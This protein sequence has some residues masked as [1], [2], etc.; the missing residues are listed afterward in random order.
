MRRAAGEL[1]GHGPAL[2]LQFSGKMSGLMEILNGA[3]A[4]LLQAREPCGAGE[5]VRSAVP[6]Y[7]ST[8]CAWWAITHWVALATA[9]TAVLCSS[10][11]SGLIN[12][13]WAPGRHIHHNASMRPVSA[14]SK[15]SV[16]H[17][18]PVQRV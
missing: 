5:Q 13:R 1:A 8:R 16:A 18:A 4:Y 10:M 3:Y 6:S 17:A 7:R 2:G 9:P 14:D 11:Q 15:L 12:M